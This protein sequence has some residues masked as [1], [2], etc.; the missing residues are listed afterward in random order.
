M[1]RTDLRGPMLGRVGGR[2][3]APYREGLSALDRRAR[4]VVMGTFLFVAARMSVMTFLGIYLV[5]DLGLGLPLVGLAFLLENLARG[6][7][8]PFAGALSDRV[9]RRPVLL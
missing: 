8:A 1:D 9:G 6:L 5:E 3:L 2:I 7:V 4:R